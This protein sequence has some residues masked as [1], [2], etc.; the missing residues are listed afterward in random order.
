MSTASDYRT[1]TMDYNAK[2]PLPFRDPLFAVVAWSA[3]AVLLIESPVDPPPYYEER[4]MEGG[5]P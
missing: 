2:C 5:R 3:V 4:T 1:A